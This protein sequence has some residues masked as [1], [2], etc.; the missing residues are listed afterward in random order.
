MI[1]P[2]RVELNSA[3]LRQKILLETARMGWPELARHFARGRVIR[4]AQGI[5]LVDVAA[6]FAQDNQTLVQKWIGD[7][8]IV[9]AN[10]DDA[11]RWNESDQV[12]WACVV[13]PWVLVQETAGT[14]LKKQ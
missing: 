7:A 1:P 14:S 8:S 12:I 11:R 3:E 5:D 9:R 2:D 13:A 6:A 4:V 10:D